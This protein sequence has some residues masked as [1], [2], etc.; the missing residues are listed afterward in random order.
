MRIIDADQLKQT[1]IDKSCYN[2]MVASII[3]RT[4]TINPYDLIDS[5]YQSTEIDPIPDEPRIVYVV[6]AHH[7]NGLMSVIGVFN[8]DDSAVHA[9]QVYK[10]ENSY[11]SWTDW[12]SF[13]I[14]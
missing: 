6:Y 12:D 14:R 9:C 4:P 8:D 13:I 5:T 3:R 11:C 10:N 2:T 1:L 7:L